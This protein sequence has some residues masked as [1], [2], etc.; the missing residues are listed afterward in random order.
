MSYSGTIKRFG[1]FESDNVPILGYEIELLTK[2]RFAP[3][4]S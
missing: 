3:A 1:M 2:T 4:S